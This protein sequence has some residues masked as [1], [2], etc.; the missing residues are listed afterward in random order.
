LGKT[1]KRIEQP[2]APLVSGCQAGGGEKG[3]ATAFVNAAFRD[4]A[5]RDSP[6]ILLE[7]VVNAVQSCVVDDGVMPDAEQQPVLHETA[8]Q[9]PARYRDDFTP[10]RQTNCGE[11][12]GF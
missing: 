6:Q 2:D 1:A 5:F 4:V 10:S 12:I 8:P 3:R 9:A 7:E 11:E